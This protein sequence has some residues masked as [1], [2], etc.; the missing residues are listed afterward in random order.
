M[1]SVSSF[2]TVASLDQTPSCPPR[3]ISDCSSSSW[4]VPFFF[5]FA[6]ADPW[7]CLRFD[8]TCESEVPLVR[9]SAGVGTDKAPAADDPVQSG[10]TPAVVVSPVEFGAVAAVDEAPAVDDPVRSGTA[11]AVVVSPVDFGAT[12]AADEAP[13]ADDLVRSGVAATVHEPKNVVDA[14]HAGPDPGVQEPCIVA[15]DND[16]TVAVGE[17]VGAVRADGTVAGCNAG[18]LAPV[19]DVPII[20]IGRLV[21]A[22]CMEGTVNGGNAGRPALGNIPAAD[23]DTTEFEKPKHG[24]KKNNFRM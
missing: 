11:A 4:G 7:D 21:V 14:S 19:F 5:L 8:A 9:F 18:R 23:D 6:F 22:V 16:G 20:A 24:D 3:Q 13:A 15:V 10:A 17:L 1:Y 2:R 12:A